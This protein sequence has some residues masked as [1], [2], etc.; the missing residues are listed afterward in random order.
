MV[1]YLII[2]VHFYFIKRFTFKFQQCFCMLYF[3]FLLPGKFQTL[4]VILTTNFSFFVYQIKSRFYFLPGYYAGCRLQQICSWQSDIHRHS[5][6]KLCLSSF[7]VQ[8]ARVPL[9]MDWW[10]RNGSSSLWVPSP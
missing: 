5:E 8:G 4:V 9:C 3:I 2:T 6:T 10:H 7:N 1:Y